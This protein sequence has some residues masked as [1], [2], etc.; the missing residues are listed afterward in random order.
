MNGLHVVNL[1]YSVKN[2]VCRLYDDETS[3]VVGYDGCRIVPS[4]CAMS[5][6][7]EYDN[8]Q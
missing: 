1:G 6:S 2:G 7:N 4:I 3:S 8:A 5:T